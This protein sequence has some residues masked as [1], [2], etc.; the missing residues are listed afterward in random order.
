MLKGD[1]SRLANNRSAMAFSI[2]AESGYLRAELRGRR[3]V[4]ETQAFLRAVVRENAKHRKPCVLLVVRL[5]QPVFQV[6]AHGFIEHIEEISG[7]P[8]CRIAVVGDTRDLQISHEYIELL[9]RQRDLNVRSFREETAALQWLNDQRK[10]AARR[11]RRERRGLWDRRQSG[12]RRGRWED[13]DTGPAIP[14]AAR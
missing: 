8:G 14:E 4:E 2:T 13:G 1:V 7:K 12:D 3:T 10:T 6:A 5:S 9:A 11:Q